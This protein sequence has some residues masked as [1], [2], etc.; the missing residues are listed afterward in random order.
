MSDL[1]ADVLLAIENLEVSFGKAT[2]TRALGGVSMTVPRGKTVGV[3]GESGS[4]KTTLGR[5]ILRLNTPS[6]GRILF[7]GRDL[8]AVSRREL[9]AVRRDIQMVFQD[10]FGSL[11]PRMRIGEIVGEPL[12]VHGLAKRA[13]LEQAVREMLEVVGL[14]Q[15]AYGRYPRE[16]SGGQRQR[17]NIARAL[18]TRPKLIIADEPTSALD[19]SIQAQIINLFQT[20]QKEFDLT[21]LFISHDLGVVRIVSDEVVVMR[22]GGI[23]ESGQATRVFDTPES[24]YTRELID[25]VPVL[26][27][28]VERERKRTLAGGGGD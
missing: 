17:I 2:V 19:V 10:P 12:R 8:A 22:A 28:R 14:P 4:G 15:N 24:D 5:A 9:H 23:V 13:Q 11:N 1:D 20:V 21:Y 16:F 26:D 7:E 6:G 27:P 25:A 18:V 3:V